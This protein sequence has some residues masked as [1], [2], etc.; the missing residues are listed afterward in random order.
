MELITNRNAIDRSSNLKHALNVKQLSLVK[1]SVIKEKIH[2]EVHNKVNV[3]KE[4]TEAKIDEDKLTNLI[5]GILNK[6]KPE[7]LNPSM[8][9]SKLKDIISNAINGKSTKEVDIEGQVDKAVGRSMDKFVNSIRDKINVPVGAEIQ[10][11][12]ID[13]EI[14]AELQQKAVDKISQDIETNKPKQTKRI[15]L[16]TRKNISDLADEL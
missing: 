14:L 8:D 13:P 10:E 5:E 2:K 4:I 12:G 3:V 15:K 1:R 16:R 6:H 9:E 11:N 7:Q